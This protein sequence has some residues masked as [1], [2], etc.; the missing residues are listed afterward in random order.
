MDVLTAPPLNPAD[1]ARVA[2]IGELL[3]A[4]LITQ[5]EHDTKVDAIVAATNSASQPPPSRAKVKKDRAPSA[6]P[7]SSA[8]TASPAVAGGPSPSAP[9]PTPPPVELVQCEGCG[10]SFLAHLRPKHQRS[11]P[12]VS[13]PAKK[14]VRFRDPERALPKPGEAPTDGAAE[15]AA[16]EKASIAFAD[17]G[18]NSFVACDKCGRTFFPDRLP[19]H[20]RACRGGKG[21]GGGGA[22]TEDT[23]ARLATLDSLLAAG[24]ITPDEHEAKRSSLLAAGDDYE[25]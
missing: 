22:T 25:A 2:S 21:K 14:T 10:E 11:C 6:A 8:A 13:K 1:A 17:N 7:A 9:T 24:L 4:G 5:Q 18:S 23:A 16:L 3:S 15:D 12:A 19:V 20:M